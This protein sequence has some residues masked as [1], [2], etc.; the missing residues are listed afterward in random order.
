LVETLGAGES[1]NRF[2]L[3]LFS[4]PTADGSLGLDFFVGRLRLVFWLGLEGFGVGGAASSSLEG[5]SNISAGPCE[6]GEGCCEI[7]LCRGLFSFAGWIGGEGGEFRNSCSSCISGVCDLVSNDANLYS[8]IRRRTALP[9]VAILFLGGTPAPCTVAMLRAGVGKGEDEGEGERC[10]LSTGVGEC[11]HN[12][13]VPGASAMAHD[14]FGGRTI[15]CGVDLLE[16]MAVKVR[17][18]KSEGA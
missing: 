5:T 7:D 4:V 11:W 1:F 18:G 6:A 8:G 3:S 9:Y 17:I 13:Y 16:K 15:C 10:M 12:K 14:V 2:L